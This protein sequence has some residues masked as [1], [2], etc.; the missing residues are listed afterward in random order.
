[1]SVFLNTLIAFKF[2][3]AMKTFSTQE[4]GAFYAHDP[5]HNLASDGD[6]VLPGEDGSIRGLRALLP[7]HGG[8]GKTVAAYEKNL[9][10]YL[11]V[12]F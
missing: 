11:L 5:V 10:K 1:M 9:V 7:V 12:F 6:E 4:P 3:T 8:K 2:N